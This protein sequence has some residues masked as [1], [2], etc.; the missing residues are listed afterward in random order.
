MDIRFFIG[1]GRVA[2]LLA[3]VLLFGIASTGASPAYA[4]Y[5]FSFAPASN[6][7]SGFASPH[8]LDAGDFNGDGKVDLVTANGN[9]PSISILLQDA[10]GTFLAAATFPAIALYAQSAI[11]LDFDLD[12]N[13]DVVTNGNL[14]QPE[15]NGVVA[16]FKGNGDGTV[17]PEINFSAGPIGGAAGFAASGDFNTDGRPDLA[18]ANNLSG[19]VSILLNQPG[20][21]LFQAPISYATGPD[22]FNV[23]VADLNADGI[24]DLVVPSGPANNVSVLLGIGDGTFQP[25]VTFDAAP[26][27][28]AWAYACVIGDFNGDATPD[29]AVAS[30]L[31]S[32]M[33]ILLGNGDGTFQTAVNYT[34]PGSRTAYLVTADFNDDLAL[35]I[36][37]SRPDAG[38]QVAAILPGNGDGTFDA[39]MFLTAIVGDGYIGTYNVLADDLNADG[40]PDLT[41]TLAV[42]DLIAVFLNTSALQNQSPVC[43]GDFTDADENFLVMGDYIVTEGATITVP[44][45]G[46][47]A[48]GDVLTATLNGPGSLSVSSGTAP[49][50][51][52]WSWTPTDADAAGA[53]Y[54]INVT[55]DDGIGEPSTCSF[56]IA[57]I[58]L[59]PT[60]VCAAQ[61]ITVECTSAAGADVMLDGSGSF[62]ADPEDAGHLIYTWHVSDAAVELDNVS[63]PTPTGTFPQGVTMATLTVV[64]QRGG[65]DVCDVIVTVQDTTP[66]EVMVTSSLAALWPPNHTMRTVN[67]FVIATDV[68]EAPEAILPIL[69]TVRSDEPDNAP[70]MG[71]GNTTGD[72]NGHDGYAAP[73]MILTLTYNAPLGGWEGSIQLRAERAGD[74]D[75]RAYIV[76]VVALDSELNAA[77]TSCVV[78]VPHDRR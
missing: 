21:P 53:P 8:G 14:Y 36:A 10:G 33:S 31:T 52:T 38:A 34:L 65:V 69:V 23:A 26:G 3:C 47:D 71:D 13:L 57:D 55:F 18:V 50:A 41:A 37:I 78:V 29:L 67:L 24:L 68:C 2:P 17:Q 60:A 64:D 30:L 43:S 22:P 72:V 15:S 19:T 4:D 25:A 75:G 40:R 39:Q 35:D 54:S 76:D 56:Q 27:D 28:G 44:F 6:Y 1:S 58:N 61:S 77:T 73:V 7:P 5:P 48:D 66:P 74:G 12:G 49:L 16:F 9:G 62:D 11:A 63:S 42:N 59:N 32:D 70:G 20:A 46:T 51:T 45:T